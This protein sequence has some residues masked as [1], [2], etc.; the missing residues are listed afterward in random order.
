ML[1]WTR[2]RILLTAHLFTGKSRLR[3][4]MGQRFCGH[5]LRCRRQKAWFL[6]AAQCMVLTRIAVG[7]E[8]DGTAY[9]GWQTQPSSPSVQAA[10]EHALSGVANEPVSVTCAGRTDA[11][12]HARWQV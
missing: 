6:P 9:A 3:P 7:I 10:I 2:L 11:G 12:V 5:Q 4:D 1:L 8:Y